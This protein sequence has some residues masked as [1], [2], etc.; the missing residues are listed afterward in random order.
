[1]IGLALEGGGS[2]G[3]YHIGVVKAYLEAGYQFDG[4]V[5]TSIG[6]I[7]AA[8][9]AQGEFEKAEEL[10]AEISTS[11]LFDDD[12]TKLIEYNI[13]RWDANVLVNANNSLKKTMDNRGI[14]SS[15]IRAVINNHI[16]EE[17]IRTRGKDLGLVTISILERRPYELFLEDIPKGYLQSYILASASFP[18]FRPEKIGNQYYMDGAL[19]NNCPV[20]ML[21]SKGYDEIIAIRTKAPGVFREI[22]APT[23]VNVKLIT[24]E[25]DLGNIMMFSPERTKETM[26]LGYQDGLRSLQNK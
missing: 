18:G 17:K 1:M 8:I 19:Y 7:N 26:T 14:D 5:G 15:R 2:R 22:E 3:A 11:Q 6:A 16:D 21:I 13:L 12:I 24:P 4:F 23:G 20:N 25:S 9:L 10:W